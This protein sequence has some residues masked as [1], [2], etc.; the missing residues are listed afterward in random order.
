MKQIVLNI[1]IELLS[2]T[3]FSSGN[4]IPGVADL[5]LRVDSQGRIYLPG[6]TL[7][8]LLRENLTNYLCWTGSGTQED[9]NELLGTEGIRSP[10]SPRRLVFSNLYPQ[11][12]QEKTAVRTFTA[13]ENGVV[14][15]GSLHTIICLTGGV[16]L[17]GMILCAEADKLLIQ[18]SVQLL[19]WIGLKRNRGF[20]HVRST[21]AGTDEIP[22][23]AQVGEGRWL[24]YRLKLQTPMAITSGTADPYDA[25][26]RNFTEGL[27]YIPGSAVRGM[28]LSWL[29]QTE[30]Q[31]FAAHKQELLQQTIFRSAL[32]V[33]DGKQ[34]LPM[35]MGFY[36]NREQTRFYSV[37]TQDVKPG[38]K[39]AK[40]GHYFRM[41]EDGSLW[42]SS[43][44]MEQ[45]LRIALAEKSKDRQMF[46]VEAMA[47][48]TVL[49]GYIH[50]PDP[51]MAPW[52]AQAF[53]QWVWI[54]A[55][56][57]AGSGLCSVEKLD[58]QA[59]DHS[60][61]GY[62]P[63]DAIPEILYL[64]V[65]SPTAL[66]CD[67]EVCGLTDGQ[68]SRLL[69]VEAQIDRCATGVMKHSGFNRTWRCA[70]PV[71]SMYAP[72]SI[73]RIVCSRV[74]DPQRL[75]ELE[76]NGI[77]IRC[78]EGCGQVLFLRD[79]EEIRDCER[80]KPQDKGMADS[81]RQRRARYSWMLKNQFPAGPSDSW[82][83]DFQA[84]CEAVLAKKQKI[85]AVED[86]LR[87]N[88]EKKGDHFPE[89]TLPVWNVFRKVMDTPLAQT[90][91]CPGHPDSPE[92]RL[93][94]LCEWMNLDRKEKM[95]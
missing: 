3:I 33:A 44:V 66:M 41:G 14:K 29:S 72:G 79:F 56:R 86:F 27:D 68:V 74:P 45:S 23:A 57:Y 82:K 49:E 67:G 51:A 25:D 40:L 13:L 6:A 85:S 37:L 70:S 39:R 4:S 80:V 35:P 30:P 89:R 75:R 59:P 81:V 88:S 16:V 18:K 34:L 61:Y 48:G 73:F 93:K 36:E 53:R 2:D 69:G 8:G 28:V 7:K 42:H 47:A 38:D 95:K 71:V 65:V 5:G 46:T 17:T 54:G 1:R 78:A 12:G 76:H 32:P 20:G 15:T 21:V 55:D 90:L 9:L 87:R 91:D 50:L 63:G 60:G 94:L 84:Q 52:I 43:P 64:M 58:N 77:G 10:E 83:G 22:A 26:R 31:W 92:L 19:Q 62:R 11:Q 24:R